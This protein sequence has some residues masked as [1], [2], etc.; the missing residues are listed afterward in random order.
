LG[1]ILGKLEWF[2]SEIAITIVSNVNDK[3]KMRIQ[4]IIVDA[5]KQ[6]HKNLPYLLFMAL[7]PFTV[8]TVIKD[9]VTWSHHGSQK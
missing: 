6:F 7:P 1:Y 2:D 4:L 3:L 9:M 5:E 8:R